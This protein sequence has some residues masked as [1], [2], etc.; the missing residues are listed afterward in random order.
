MRKKPKA[1]YN[2]A[3][4]DSIAVR[5]AIRVRSRMFAMSELNPTEMD[6]VLDLG[7]TSDF[8]LF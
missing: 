7:V 4:L 6:E 1:Q 3:E 5:I 2:V 8:Q